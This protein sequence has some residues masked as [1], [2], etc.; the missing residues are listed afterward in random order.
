MSAKEKPEPKPE[1]TPSPYK[2][3]LI[4]VDELLR[5]ANA[6]AHRVATEL[7]AVY[8]DPEFLADPTVGNEEKAIALLDDYA[9][10]LFVI[11]PEERSPFLDLRA[12]LAMY[13]KSSEWKAGNLSKMYDAMVVGQER[14]DSPSTRN[15]K[16]RVKREE[17]DAIVER[18]QRTEKQCEQLRKENAALRRQ[19]GELQAEFAMEPVA[20]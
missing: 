7:V 10:R 1:A 11:L 17:Y 4:G 18:L 3:R 20:A 5:N 16:P 14:H 6:N 2:T 13:P 15:V 19:I 9:R 8:D 12:M